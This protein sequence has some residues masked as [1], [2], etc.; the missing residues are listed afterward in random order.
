MEIEFIQAHSFPE[1]LD[2]TTVVLDVRDYEKYKKEH[3]PG[4]VWMPGEAITGGLVCLMEEKDYI[5]YCDRGNYSLLVVQS[6][7][8]QGYRA[9]SL[10]GGYEAYRAEKMYDPAKKKK[11]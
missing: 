9:K 1:V 6:M 10:Y 5:V 4:A 2:P 7:L 3:I 11:N 8:R